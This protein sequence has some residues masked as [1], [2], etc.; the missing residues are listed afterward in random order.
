MVMHSR[1]FR[2]LGFFV[3]C[4]A[5]LALI[6]RSAPLTFHCSLRRALK[7]NTVI[8]DMPALA[9]QKYHF[10]VASVG[11]WSAT[12]PSTSESPLRLQ[13]STASNIHTPCLRCRRQDAIGA[14]TAAQTMVQQGILSKVPSKVATDPTMSEH[15][16]KTWVPPAAPRPLSVEAL[17]PPP[18]SLP[19]SPVVAPV[20]TATSL[21]MQ[22]RSSS[23]DEDLRRCEVQQNLDRVGHDIGSEAASDATHCCQLCTQTPNCQAWTFVQESTGGTCWL[24]SAIGSARPDTRCTSG[25]VKPS[26]AATPSPQPQPAKAAMP[27]PTHNGGRTA[28]DGAVRLIIAVPTVARDS[29]DYLTPTVTNLLAEAAAAVA[30]GVVASVDLLIFSHTVPHSAYESIKQIHPDSKI[31]S[32][33]ATPVRIFFRDDAAPGQRL[34]DPHANDQQTVDDHRNPDDRP[35][36][37]VR[38]QSMDMIAMLRWIAEHVESRTPAPASTAATGDRYFVLMSEDDAPLCPGGLTKIGRAILAAEDK[39]GRAG[40]PQ[41]GDRPKSGWA[42]LRFSIGFIGIVL[43]LPALPSFGQ[44]LRRCVVS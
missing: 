24:K 2:K 3:G 4:A 14:K 12:H 31:A 6:L 19:P 10:R 29:V 38:Q 37:K 40:L 44:F 11:H 39:F 32:P 30:E 27:L 34:L 1:F 21:L 17:P 23:Q 22:Q 28:S 25:T 18:S 36:V 20:Q 33:D 16:T 8:F 7:C 5:A 15:A 9:T 43:P 26:A 42:S 13:Q 41:A 35:G